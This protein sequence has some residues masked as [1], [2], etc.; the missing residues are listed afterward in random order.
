MGNAVTI[1]DVK[2]YLQISHNAQDVILNIA[3]AGVEEWIETYCGISLTPKTNL[4]EYMDGGTKYLYVSCNPLVQVNSVKST[5]GG[6][7]FNFFINNNAI[8]Q[9]N[10]AKWPFG[11][12]NI[13][14]NYDAGYADINSVPSGI[15]IAA[16]QLLHRW[17]SNRSG[18]T[19]Q[20]IE[21]FRMNFAEIADSDIVKLIQPFVQRSFVF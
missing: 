1:T 9:T 19:S 12:S 7:T 3:I 6:E 15:K 17:Y 16:Y 2:S 11:D 5:L 21:G 18:V 10:L 8:M 20:S 13:L 14:V 4:L